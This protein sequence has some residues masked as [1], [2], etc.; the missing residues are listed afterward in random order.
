MKAVIAAAL[1]SLCLTLP[2][3]ASPKVYAGDE[4]RAIHCAHTFFVMGILGYEAGFLSRNDR[5]RMK[6]YALGVMH[7]YTSGNPEQ[8]IKALKVMAKRMDL[9]QVQRQ[10]LTRAKSCIRKFPLK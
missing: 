6:T 1:A 8:K 3:A 7:R 10:Y 4:A 5:D 2:A 9:E